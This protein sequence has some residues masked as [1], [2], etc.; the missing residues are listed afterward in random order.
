M[1]DLSDAL[2]ET[3]LNQSR[4]AGPGFFEA[5]TFVLHLLAQTPQFGFYL[6]HCSGPLIDTPQPP[7]KVTT[8]GS[9]DV[10]GVS[11]VGSWS[12]AS[13]A[14]STLPN[15]SSLRLRIRR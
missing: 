1:K 7:F 5:F 4:C 11:V 2:I 15:K 12:T 8:D 14:S 13:D 6:A 3:R 9:R 10:S